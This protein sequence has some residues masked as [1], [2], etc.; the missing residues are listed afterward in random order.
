MTSEPA[1]QW[2][3]AV[4]LGTPAVVA[5]WTGSNRIGPHD[6]EGFPSAEGVWVT[7]ETEQKHDRVLDEVVIRIYVVKKGRRT[8]CANA[9]RD[10]R[11]AMNLNPGEPKTWAVTPASKGLRVKNLK[12]IPSAPA[13]KSDVDQSYYAGILRYRLTG[14][15]TA[16]TA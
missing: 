10:I 12:L 5:N 9:M 11:N 7:A 1:T 2:V 4:L 3:I 16:L 14:R 6:D 8:D 13:G 15:A